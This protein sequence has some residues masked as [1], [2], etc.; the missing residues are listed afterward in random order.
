MKTLTLLALAGLG[1]Q[2]VDGSLGMAYGVTSTTLLLAVGTNPAA[3]SATVHLAEIG[4]T[5]ASGAAHWRFG[6]VDWRVV[7]RIGIPGAAGAFAG[8]TVLAGLS[9]DVAK[10]VMALILLLL[11]LYVLGRFTFLGLPTGNLGKPL[12]RRF[13]T[14]LGVVAGF[15]DATGGGGW[16]PVGTPALLAGGRLEPRKVIGSIDTSEFLVAVAA[17]TGF[18]VGL[19][20]EGIDCTWAVALLAGG[21]IAAPVAAWLVRHVPPRILGSAVGGLIVLTNVRTLLR[22][23]WLGAGDAARWTVYALLH[24]VWAAALAYSFREHRRQ[25][26][27][28]VTTPTGAS[29]RTTAPRSRTTV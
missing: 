2:L 24:A 5:L 21:L 3:A 20:S 29:A 7:A 19:G 12:R 18:L 23:D 16:G 22:G 6:N 4:T 27:G 15:L 14:P 17:S 8:A 25:S 28:P 11:G 26:A 9:T 13:L 1:A 10:P